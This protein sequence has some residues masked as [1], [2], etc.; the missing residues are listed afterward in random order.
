MNSPAKQPSNRILKRSF[1]IMETTKIEK[2][3]HR[4]DKFVALIKCRSRIIGMIENM[5]LA[6]IKST[7]QSQ[8]CISNRFSHYT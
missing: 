5:T 2:K 1:H 6:G 7:K 8:C 3:M 4:S